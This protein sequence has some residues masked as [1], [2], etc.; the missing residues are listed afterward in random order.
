MSNYLQLDALRKEYGTVAAVRDMSL[1]IAKGELFTLLGPSGCGKSTTLS[2]LAGLLTPTS[3]RIVLDGRDITR[4]P[5]EARGLGVVF[6]SYALF[7]HMT[8]LDNV[9]FPLRM[10]GLARKEAERRARDALDL[11]QLAIIRAY[12]S[13]ISG[14]QAQRVAFAR[15]LVFEPHM[16]LMDEPLAAL[17]RSLRRD[18]QFELRSL[19]RR[20]NATIIYVTHDQEEALVLSD[21]IGVMKNGSLEQVAPPSEIYSNPVNAFVAGFLG[22]SNS[23]Q[24]NVE[25][26][27]GEVLN[28]TPTHEPRFRVP[29]RR[30]ASLLRKGVF[31]VRPEHVGVLLPDE[32]APTGHFSCA[33][34]VEDVVFL[35]DHIRIEASTLGTTGWK[36]KLRPQVGA[37]HANRLELGRSVRLHWP[38]EAALLLEDSADVQVESSYSKNS[39]PLLPQ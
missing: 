3:G 26:N 28:V 15:A 17:D 18:M 7:P 20:V 38:I 9:I 35:G 1:G 4:L 39:A 32:A 27:G 14:G 36:A 33:G 25:A 34:I 13:E 24:V 21:R 6:Q 12:P 30:P 8:V 2:M 23:F 10:R 29:V 11:V 5:P 31:F 16:L 37:Y 19:Q 22:E